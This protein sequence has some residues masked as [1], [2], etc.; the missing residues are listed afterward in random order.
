MRD[1]LIN[2]GSLGNSISRKIFIPSPLIREE[3][4]REPSILTNS[5]KRRLLKIDKIVKEKILFLKSRQSG[6]STAYKQAQSKE[7]GDK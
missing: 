1:K 7:E 4:L 5:D 2:P 6:L 3:G